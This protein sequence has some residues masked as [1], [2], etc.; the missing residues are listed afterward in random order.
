MAAWP[1]GIQRYATRVR[2]Q[3]A[4]IHAV[5]GESDTA[6]LAV[7]AFN[8]VQALPSVACRALL[9]PLEDALRKRGS[10]TFTDLAEHAR[11]VRQ[12]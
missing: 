4:T 3:L 1:D 2:I 10:S 5:T 9:T 8:A 11:R 6:K 12:G 7:A